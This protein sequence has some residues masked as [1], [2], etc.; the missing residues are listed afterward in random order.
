MTGLLLIPLPVRHWSDARV[1]HVLALDAGQRG[2]D[3]EGAVD[4]AVGV[5]HAARH[6]VHHAL[7]SIINVTCTYIMSNRVKST[8]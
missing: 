8:A 5:H 4:P 7:Q 6:A 3:G 2:G 1:R